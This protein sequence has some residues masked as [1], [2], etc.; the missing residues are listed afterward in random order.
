[1]NF[2]SVREPDNSLLRFTKDMDVGLTKEGGVCCK[3]EKG[4]MV[5]YHILG[6]FSIAN[7]EP[8]AATK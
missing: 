2:A 4:P 6:R 8:S 7:V 3:V 1:L 5:E